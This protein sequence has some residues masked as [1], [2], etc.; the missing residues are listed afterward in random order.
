MDAHEQ[1]G[2]GLHEYLQG[3]GIPGVVLQREQLL[4]RVDAALVAAK[5]ILVV[6]DL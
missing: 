2:P 6:Y 4:Y 3:V 1:L 5:I